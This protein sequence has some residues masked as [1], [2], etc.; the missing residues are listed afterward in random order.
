V[1]TIA[2]ETTKMVRTTFVRAL[3]CIILGLLCLHCP[4]SSAGEPERFELD[5][6]L[7]VILRPISTAEEVAVVTLYSIGGDHDP[8]GRSGM[9]HLTEH[10][11]VTAAAGSTPARTAFEYMERYPDGWNAQT[12]ARYTVFATVSPAK[13]LEDELQ[14][15]A[16]RMGNLSIVEPDLAREKPR[17]VRELH[18]MYRDIPVLAAFQNVSERIQPSPLGGRKGGLADHVNALTVEELQSRWQR[19]YKPKNAIL[20]VAG[21]FEPATVRRLITEHFTEISPGEPA[22]PPYPQGEPRLGGMEEVRVQP[23]KKD[24]HGQVCVG[25]R[26]PYPNDELYPAFLIL[27][28]RLTS[29]TSKLDVNEGESTVSYTALD[30]PEVIA[31]TVPGAEGETSEE[32]V[33]RLR[34]FVAETVERELEP[35][36]ATT[37][38]DAY[39]FLLGLADIPD[40]VLAK[41]PYGV[42]F[43]LGRRDQL[44]IDSEKLA[45][46][47]DAVTDADLRQAAQEHFAPERSAAVA[48]IIEE[49]P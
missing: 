43:S 21:G 27:A 24:A 32:T 47:L 31:V 35:F 15:A 42:A 36:D 29:N 14:D 45:E 16:N 13:S 4:G 46:A 33:E 48:I 40:R 18:N 11:Y 8:E 49:T 7:H 30:C 3:I 22:P 26:A 19:Y 23:R 28:A 12:G 37:T 17:L 41:N 38:K 39:G 5:N 25:Y 1:A 20:A 34:N 9:A 44:G 2:K 6:G 10:V